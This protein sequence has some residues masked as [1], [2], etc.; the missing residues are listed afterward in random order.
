MDKIAVH[1]PNQYLSEAVQKHQF[2]VYGKRWLGDVQASREVISEPTDE[3]GKNAVIFVGDKDG[4]IVY[5]NIVHAEYR[6]FE[7]ISVDEYFK[8][9]DK[10]AL[11]PIRIGAHEVEFSESCITVGGQNVTWEEITAILDR[12]RELYGEWDK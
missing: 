10:P 2:V 1:V 6:N 7:I 4:A 12:R 8:R 3:Y 5:Q 9:F 11:P